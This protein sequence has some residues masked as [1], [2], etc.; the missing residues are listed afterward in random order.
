MKKQDQGEQPEISGKT[1]FYVECI[2]GVVGV[3]SL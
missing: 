2:A 3:F 1:E